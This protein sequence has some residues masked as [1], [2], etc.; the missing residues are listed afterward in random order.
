[1]ETK[2]IRKGTKVV[3]RDAGAVRFGRPVEKREGVGIV[4]DLF[5]S[6]RGASGSAPYYVEF[7]DG[8]AQWFDADEVS[9]PAA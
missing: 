5:R 3:T 8:H 7:S 1:M 6:Y 9:R 2:T 4:R